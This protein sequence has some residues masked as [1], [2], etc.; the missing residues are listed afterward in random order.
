MGR[1][2]DSTGIQFR[3]LNRSRGPAVQAPRAQAD[4]EAYSRRMRGAVESARHLTLIEGET[5]DLIVDGG[6]LRG[7]AL[8]G[9]RALGAR[10]AVVTTGT[11]LRGLLHVGLENR[12]GGRFAEKTSV[13]L[14]RAL[15]GLG[16]PMGRLKTGTPPRVLKSSVD[17]EAMET[18][19]GDRDPVPFSF[20]TETIDTPQVD[21]HITFTNPRTHAIIRGNLDRSPLYTGLITSAGPR[22]CP[23]IEDKIV[24]F[25][26]R[27]RHQIFVEPEGRDHPWIY[28]NGISTSLP[29]EAQTDMVRSIRGLERAEVARA[30]YAVEYDFVQPTAC[31]HTLEARTVR[32]LFLAGQINGTTGYEEAAALGLVAGINAALAAQDREPLVLS[33]GEAYIGVLVDDLVLKGTAEPYRMFTSRA[34]YRLLLDID[35]A[36]LRL[37]EHGRRVGLIGDERYRRF[38]D[39]RDG[40]RAF[41]R[42]LETQTLRPS[43]DAARRAERALGICIGEPTTPALLLRRNDVTLDGLLDGL[44]DETAPGL[45]ARDRRYVANRLRYGGYIDRQERDLERLQREEGRRIPPEFGYEGLP[46]LSREIVEKLGRARPATLAQAA[47][48]SGVTPAALSL[49]N[50]YLE[51]ARRQRAPRTSNARGTA[52]ARP[53]RR[54]DTRCSEESSDSPTPRLPEDRE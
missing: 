1:A 16:L 40:V 11:F 33:R 18:Q 48:I 24:R 37:T 20:D 19:A 38:R 32:G 4:K 39:R 29:A 15:A 14:S 50:V 3:L 28:L 7:V 22:Y 53:R 43:T 54:I 46:G 44:G 34:E 30:G 27:D 9:G 35:S 31:R 26:D 2:I 21:C 8:A 25:A 36:D 52:P 13:G 49:I 12:P 51:K 6:V 10:C 23:S 41:T 47:R 45:G 42:F 17:F 5:S